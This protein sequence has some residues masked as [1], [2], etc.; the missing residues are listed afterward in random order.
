VTSNSLPDSVL[1]HDMWLLQLNI[2][3]AVRCSKERD[4]KRSAFY[5]NTC[6]ATWAA[7]RAFRLLGE[8]AP[9]L[10]AILVDELEEELGDGEYMETASERA[11]QAGVDVD[12][13]A[14]EIRASLTADP[15]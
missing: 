14:G 2:E 5:A 10:A 6:A 12:G 13:F 4:P 7:H 11:E 1:S 15:A 8:I 3:A 9:H